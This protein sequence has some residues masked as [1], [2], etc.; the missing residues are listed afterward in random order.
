MP[1]GKL[2]I[3]PEPQVLMALTNTPLSPLDAICEL[4]DNGIDS[5]RAAAIEGTPVKSPWIQVEVPGLAEIRNGGGF[6]RIS[7]NGVGLDAEGLSRALTA[8]FSSKNAFDTLGLFGMG[9]NI[10]TGKLG[11]RTVVTTMRRGDDFAIQTVL[12]LPELVRRRSF[13]LEL[14]RVEK[15]SGLE[16]GTVIEISDWW[17]E[18]QQNAGFV[19]KL[20]AESKPA[21]ARQLGRR[22][23]SILRRTDAD[24]IQM[25]LNEHAVRGFEHCVW[26]ETRFVERQ[27]WGRIP[28]KI[29]F[30]EILHTQRHCIADRTLIGDAEDCCGQ[31]GGV[32]FKSIQERV[33][34]WVGVQRFDDTDKFGIDVIR[35]GRTILV[36]EKDAFF[37]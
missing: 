7:D 1:D 15:P 6:I 32:D 27:G 28:A 19:Q 23:A 36:S 14:I 10:A 12:D 22:Y 20:A 29:T 33:R 35:N 8:G 24:R 9:F 11:M 30:D 26:D 3:T 25:R 4:V 31:C 37:R 16:S 13:D 18:G 34:G 2:N 5:F 17:P 21:L